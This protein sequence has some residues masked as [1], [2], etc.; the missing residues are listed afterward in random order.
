[1]GAKKN[2]PLNMLTM[3]TVSQNWKS[4][5]LLCHACRPSGKSGKCTAPRIE[6][7]SPVCAAAPGRYCVCASHGLSPGCAYAGIGTAG[8]GAAALGCIAGCPSNKGWPVAA[9]CKTSDDDCGCALLL[10]GAAGGTA[11]KAGDKDVASV[12]PCSSGSM[13]LSS[14]FDAGSFSLCAAAACVVARRCDV[15]GGGRFANARSV[16]RRSGRRGFEGGVVVGDPS[17]VA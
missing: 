3:L 8:T 1:M 14:M 16:G 15:G 17:E 9:P 5:L 7:T 13:S 2:R 11:A 4:I 6:P 10:V 12:S